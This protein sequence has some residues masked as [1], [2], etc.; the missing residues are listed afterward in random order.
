MEAAKEMKSG[1]KVPQGGEDDAPTSNTRI[2]QRK[3][4]ILHSTIK[5][6]MCVVVTALCNQPEA[7]AL[8][9]G[10]DQSRY[11]C[12]PYEYYMYTYDMIN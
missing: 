9:V 6:M 2:A 12:L 4:A 1:T 7:F 5:N 11:L 10:D 3:C 8:D